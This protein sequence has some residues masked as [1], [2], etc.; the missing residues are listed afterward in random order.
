MYQNRK[1]FGSVI[2]N[3]QL[4]QAKLRDM[5]INIDASAFLIFRVAWT[6]TI[7]YTEFHVKQR[8]PCYLL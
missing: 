8:W 5:S 4:I 1:M 6:K 7:V 3:L 2:I